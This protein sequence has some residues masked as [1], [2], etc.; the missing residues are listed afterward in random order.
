MRPLGGAMH[1]TSQPNVG[2]WSSLHS[3]L[4]VGATP[5]AVALPVELSAFVSCRAMRP[6]PRR[7]GLPQLQT[8][9]LEALDH[10]PQSHSQGLCHLRNH[11]DLSLQRR[12]ES[13]QAGDRFR[14]P[15]VMVAH[16]RKAPTRGSS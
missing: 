1:C 10:S 9:V 3:L 7:W 12:G 5:L 11:R 13:A 15:D 6:T 2:S 8:L 16:G 4:M 14:G